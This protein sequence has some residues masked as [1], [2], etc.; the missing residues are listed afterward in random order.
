NGEAIA[1]VGRDPFYADFSNRVWKLKDDLEAAMSRFTA[2]AGYAAAAK[3]AV[4]LNT[5]NLD[6]TRVPWVA[7]VSPHK[8][9]R[10]IPGTRQQI[11]PTDWLTQELPEAAILFSWN[12]RDE[13]LRRNQA[14]RDQGGRFIVPI[15]EVQVL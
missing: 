5:Y 14:Y 3:G 11:V 2:V 13:V 9:G 15:P 6:A 12:I 1:G 7:D 8:H 10:F 4:L